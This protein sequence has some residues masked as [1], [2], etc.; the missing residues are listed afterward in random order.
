MPSSVLEWRGGV[1]GPFVR[2][3]RARGYRAYMVLHNRD[4][5]LAE[6]EADANFHIFD[7]GSTQHPRALNTSSAYLLPYRYMDPQGVRALSSLG[8]AIFDA[9]TVDPGTAI[10]LFDQLQARF[11]AGRVSRYEQLKQHI[12]VPADCIAVFLQTESYR[13]VQETCY[14][15]LRHMVKALLD[16][17]DPRP[18]VIKPHPRDTDMDTYTWLALK[19][20]KDARLTITSANIHDILSRAAVA[21]TINSAV[22][23][24]AFL[25]RCPVV[26][27]GS[28]D[29]HHI[30]ESVRDRDAMDAS[31]IRALSRKAAGDWPFEAY[32]AWFYG[33][34]LDPTAPDFIDRFIS[35]LADRG[36]FL[37]PGL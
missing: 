21:V 7:H 17:D 32:I 2:T 26:L 28:A 10:P 3:L 18:I 5:A 36:Y 4:T 22:G 14:L 15:S 24:E 25:H 6:V 20:K 8:Q 19:A 30:C 27:C 9:G 23:I 1:Y 16:R 12:D 29:F 33:Q 37:Q 34:M 31:I 11:V 35:R 13:S